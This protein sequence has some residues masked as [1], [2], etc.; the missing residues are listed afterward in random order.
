[1]SIKNDW[2]S[3]PPLENAIDPNP[4]IVLPDRPL[5]QVI[6]L[7]NQANA[8][9]CRLPG[10]TSEPTQI[11]TGSH[12]CVLVMENQ[13]LMGIFTE[14]DIIDLIANDS[15]NNPNQITIAQVMRARVIT[16]TKTEHQDIFAALSLLREHQIRYL[17]VLDI[18]G[19]L[20]GIVTPETIRACVQPA[21]LLQWRTV[22]DV[23]MTQVFQSEET[24]SVSS[25]IKVMAEHKTS[26]IVITAAEDNKENISAYL[27]ESKCDKFAPEYPGDRHFVR[28]Y[29]EQK[30]PLIAVG[31]VS[32][33]EILQ[34]QLL[35]INLAKTLARDIMNTP[36]LT[37]APHESLWVANQQ[38]QRHQTHRLVVCG[39]RGEVLG[40]LTHHCLLQVFD[41]LEMSSV[42]EGLQQSIAQQTIQLIK[43][44]EQLHE[45][46]KERQRTEEKLQKLNHELENRVMERTIALQTSNDELI[47]EIIRRKQ[48]QEALRESQERLWSLI[49]TA[50]S[51][52]IFLGPDHR[53]LQWNLEAERVYGWQ[54]IEVLG[55]SYLDIC[56]PWEM[57]EQVSH[58]L[59][60]VFDGTPQRDLELPGI[61]KNGNRQPILL[62][63]LTPLFDT[64]GEAL[65]AIISGQEITDRKHAEAQLWQ[66]KE[67]LEDLVAKRTAALTEANQK[68]RREIRARQR[69]EQ[70]LFQEKEL[71]QVTL[72]SIGEGVITTDTHGYIQLINPMAEEILTWEAE[73]AFG[74]PVT[75]VFKIVHEKSKDPLP[76][77]IEAALL[78]ETFVD[79]THKSVLMVRNGKELAISC[80]AAPIRAS[81]GKIVGAVLVFRDVTHSRNMARQLSWQASHDPLTGLINRR[82]FERRLESAVINSQVDNL[83]HT[84]CYLDLDRF[85]IVNDTSGHAAG[86]ELLRKISTLLSSHLRKSDVLGRLGGDEFAAILYNC[87]VNEAL[88]VANGMRESIK[89]FEFVWDQHTFTIGVSIGLVAINANTANLQSVLSEADAACYKAKKT[90]RDRV[91]IHTI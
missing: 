54:D 23:M 50:G 86:D 20:I 67:H 7:M 77:P 52:I 45:E 88:R 69:A 82:E 72:Q 81:D 38:M 27:P 62:W 8:Y 51:V 58:Y 89:S 35:Q 46:V 65:G 18:H 68:L 63:N 28:V 75:E 17:P 29:Q 44:N 36:V 73:A 42:I 83:E 24:E 30:K 64:Q 39:D 11:D 71:A 31:I 2:N 13:Q 14:R 49:Q 47:A 37:I 43:S 6:E 57:R 84:L 53:I 70:A 40:L 33:N 66:Y 56:V 10:F 61:T 25:L 21:N 19:Q 48:V 12:R 76:N 59:N 90:G 16:L 32:E 15:L 85:K 78:G 41:V 3:V 87:S 26:F 5:D 80:T 91:E 9:N 79:N 55:E 60:E 4:L 1:M 74:L 22:R 34:C